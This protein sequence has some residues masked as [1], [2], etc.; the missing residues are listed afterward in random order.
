MGVSKCRGCDAEIV[1]ATTKAGKSMPLD[2][3]PHPE[4]NIEA[5]ADASGR[6]HVDVVHAEDQATMFGTF[7]LSHFVTCPNAKEFRTR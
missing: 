6:W 1:W 2:P 5:H 4:G 3:R 7:Y